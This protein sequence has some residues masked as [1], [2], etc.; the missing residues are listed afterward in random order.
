LYQL[1]NMHI[2]FFMEFMNLLYLL[3]K[4]QILL[5]IYCHR[6]EELRNKRDNKKNKNDHKKSKRTNKLLEYYL[7]LFN[8]WPKAWIKLALNISKSKDF[9]KCYNQVSKW[10]NQWEK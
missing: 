5:K 4:Y 3:K 2:K 1:Y 6:I 7:K 10:I 9:S 8:K